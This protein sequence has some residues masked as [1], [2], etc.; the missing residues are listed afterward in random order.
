MCDESFSAALN[1]LFTTYDKHTLV[2]EEFESLQ[3]VHFPVDRWLY[4]PRPLWL[5]SVARYSVM[6][7]E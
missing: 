1:C 7:H 3:R 2:L 5:L 6:F 4:M